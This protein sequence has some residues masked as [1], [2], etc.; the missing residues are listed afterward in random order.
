MS[1]L[2]EINPTTIRLLWLAFSFL[3]ASIALGILVRN[4]VKKLLR[5]DDED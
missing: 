5:E 3:C 1:D 2:T 4:H